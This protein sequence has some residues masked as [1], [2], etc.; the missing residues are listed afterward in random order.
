MRCGINPVI[1][2]NCLNQNQAD[3][4]KVSQSGRPNGG[5]VHLPFASMNVVG[6]LFSVCDALSFPVACHE[7]K[8]ADRYGGWF[9]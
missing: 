3:V 4:G 9:R 1:R 5:L 7:S 8:I 6:D 2:L